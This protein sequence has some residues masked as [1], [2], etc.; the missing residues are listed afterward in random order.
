MLYR[1]ATVGMPY[2]RPRL[3]ATIS[4]PS[5]DMPYAFCGLEIRS[6]VACISSGPPHSRARD[7]PL[8]RGEGALRPHPGSCSPSDRA[9]VESLAH[10][11]LRGGHHDPGDVEALGHDD[12]VEQ[13]GRDH[14]HVGEP[15]EVGQVVLVGGE[16][17]DGV[18]PAQ[19]VREQVAVADVALVEV[20]LRAQVRGP[21]V[22]VHRRGQRVEHD[23]V[24]PERQEP[25][26][27][28]R[29]DE[30]GAAGDK[31]LHFR[32]FRRRSATSRYTSRVAAAVAPQVNCAGA[33]ESEVAQAIP[34]RPDRL[35]DGPGDGR[36][37]PWGRP[38]PRLRPRS[39]AWRWCP[40]SRPG[41]RR[42]WPPGWA[43]RRSR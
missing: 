29:A 34:A 7:V 35:D 32:R 4:S 13:R 28:V 24:M 31:D 23:D 9:P 15:R 22:P 20:D 19:E 5:L 30:P 10:G 39:P 2:R 25:V 6:G 16:V 38:G 36:R 26:A 12:L 27:G 43:A 37:D 40:R 3:M 18:H 11:R 14:V 21:P 17:V 42:P 8:A 33:L 1:S 41:S